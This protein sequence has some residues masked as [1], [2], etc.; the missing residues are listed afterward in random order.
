[1]EEQQ[2]VPASCGHFPEMDNVLQ[3]RDLFNVI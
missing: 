3:D 2:G 1:M